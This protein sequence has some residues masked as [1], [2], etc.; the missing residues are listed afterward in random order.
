MSHTNAVKTKSPTSNPR[1]NRGRY[2]R[3]LYNSGG[4][5]GMRHNELKREQRAKWREQRAAK[6]AAAAPHKAPKTKMVLL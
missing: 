2:V 3:W 1:L 5:F 6:V 4:S